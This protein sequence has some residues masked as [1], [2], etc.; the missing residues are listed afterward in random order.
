MALSPQAETTT[1]AWLEPGSVECGVP[2]RWQPVERNQ[3]AQSPTASGLHE[4]PPWTPTSVTMRK[5][6]IL[7]PAPATPPPPAPAN[8]KIHGSCIRENKG[9][10]S[11]LPPLTPAIA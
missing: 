10:S 3:Q 1:C 9:Y 5:A 8:V 11:P 4:L 6:L 7:F 2:G